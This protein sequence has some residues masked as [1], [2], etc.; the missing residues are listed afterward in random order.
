MARWRTLPAEQPSAADSASSIDDEGT[1]EASD[2]PGVLGLFAGYPVLARIA[3]GGMGIVY[4]ALDPALNRLVAIKVLSPQLA[5]SETARARFLREA[6][7]AAAVV[8]ESVVAIHAV[9]EERGLPYLVMQ[10]IAGKSLEARVAHG[11]L[12]LR[13]ILRIGMQTALGLAAAH[14]QGLIHRDVKPGNILLENGVERV[15]LTDFG[16]A[17]AVDEPGVTRAGVLAGTPEFMSPEQA[18]GERLTPRSDLF[19]LGAVLHFIATGQ[20]PF[21]AETTLATLRRVCED[22]PARLDRLNPLLPAW[23]ADL[24]LRL[25]AKAPEHRYSTAREVATELQSRLE[26][27]QTDDD[28]DPRG[29]ALTKPP[30]D[31]PNLD[32][33][34]LPTPRARALALFALLLILSALAAKWWGRSGSTPGEPAPARSPDVALLRIS[35]DGRSESFPTLPAALAHAAPHDILELA[36]DGPLV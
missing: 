5:S 13:E 8:H 7:A 29:R 32:S 1:L 26:Q 27:T 31:L 24:V 35:T 33:R 19:S 18:R 21:R 15:K 12:S 9:G 6:R 3:S 14:A 17:R 11:P 4:Q 22:T 23:L 30:Q 2:Q 10:F 16:L 25:L 34:A 28:P 20:S 36:F